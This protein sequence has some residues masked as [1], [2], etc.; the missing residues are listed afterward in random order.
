MLFQCYK[1][2]ED[3]NDKVD[4]FNNLFQDTQNKHAPIML[5]TI[6]SRPNPYITLEI[7]QMMKL[8]TVGTKEPSRQRISFIGMLIAFSDKK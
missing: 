8:A 2:F 5:I 1:I 7:R 4:A 6:K 3:F